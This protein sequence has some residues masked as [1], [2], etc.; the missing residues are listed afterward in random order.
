MPNRKVTINH[1][2]VLRAWCQANAE[3]EAHLTPEECRKAVP[4]LDGALEL[5]EAAD[6]MEGRT[7]ANVARVLKGLDC[8]AEDRCEECPYSRMDNVGMACE[9]QLLA[10]ARV[11]LAAQQ[12]VMDALDRLLREEDDLK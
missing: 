1:L 6:R 5:L 10:E 9:R 7:P 8:C 2:R 12:R 4:W 11:A 3:F